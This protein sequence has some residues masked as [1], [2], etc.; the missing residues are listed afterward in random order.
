MVH[1]MPAIE[2]LRRRFVYSALAFAEKVEFL[3]QAA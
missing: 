3:L 1:N 2:L